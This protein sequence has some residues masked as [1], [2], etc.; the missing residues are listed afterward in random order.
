[1]LYGALEI[2]HYRKYW[3]MLLETIQ[4]CNFNP[5]LGGLFRSSFCGGGGGSYFGQNST[6]TKSNSVRAVLEIFSVLFPVF[7]R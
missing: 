2:F 5:N 7:V 1:M 3:I 4:L 6:F